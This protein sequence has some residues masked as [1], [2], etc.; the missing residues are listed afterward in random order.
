MR[1]R[2]WRTLLEIA[3]QSP[4]ARFRLLVL[5]GCIGRNMK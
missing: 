1:I 3:Q 5:P 4:S 2:L